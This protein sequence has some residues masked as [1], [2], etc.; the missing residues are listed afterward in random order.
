MPIETTRRRVDVDDCHR[1]VR[2]GILLEDDRVELIDGDRG[3]KPAVSATAD[4][5]EY[6][7]VDVAARFLHR[8]TE[9]ATG[10]VRWCSA[11]RPAP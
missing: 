1:M 3:V 8:Y 4:V 5:I 9:P 11:A 2:A 10:R 6:R 7:L